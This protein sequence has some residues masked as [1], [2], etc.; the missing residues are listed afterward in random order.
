MSFSAPWAGGTTAERHVMPS[1]VVRT[2]PV[3]ST[4]EHGVPPTAKKWVLVQI[5]ARSSTV[6]TGG[7]HA[8]VTAS[9]L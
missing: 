1:E 6:V 2:A 8:Q 9:P 7:T 3:A 5:T 4:L